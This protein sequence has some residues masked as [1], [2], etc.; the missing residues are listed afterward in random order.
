MPIAAD[1]AVLAAVVAGTQTPERPSTRVGLDAEVGADEDQRLLDPA[2]VRDHV[3][4]RRA[5]RTIG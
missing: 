5:A 2:D 1:L 3:D 4:R